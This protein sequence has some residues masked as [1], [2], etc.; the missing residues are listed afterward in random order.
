MSY[1][2]ASGTADKACKLQQ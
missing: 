2:T 1:P